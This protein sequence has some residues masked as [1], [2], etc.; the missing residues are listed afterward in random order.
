LKLKFYEDEECKVLAHRGE[1][2]GD[3]QAHHGQL[4]FVRYSVYERP[5]PMMFHSKLLM[6]LP[7]KEFEIHAEDS[8]PRHTRLTLVQREAVA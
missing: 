7:P 2:F 8:D 3:P 5:V 6:F 1:I 4:F